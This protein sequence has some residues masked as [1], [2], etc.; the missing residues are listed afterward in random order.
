MQAAAVASVLLVPV[1]IYQV[2]TAEPACESGT[3]VR[4]LL[5]TFALVS[6]MKKYCGLDDSCIKSII[7]LLANGA[8]F[9]R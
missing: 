9:T 4:W 2:N 5:A 8:L 3:G 1:T 6:I 7:F